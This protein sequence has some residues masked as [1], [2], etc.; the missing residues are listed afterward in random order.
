MSEKKR[1]GPHA[2]AQA[3][4]G[5]SGAAVAA[6]AAAAARRPGASRRPHT[7][8]GRGATAFLFNSVV[9]LS[10]RGVVVGEVRCSKRGNTGT[11][12]ISSQSPHGAPTS[13][14]DLKGR[15]HPQQR[16]GPDARVGD[17]WR[18]CTAGDSN[19][20]TSGTISKERFP[21]WLVRCRSRHADMPAARTHFPGGSTALVGALS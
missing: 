12:G 3:G 19:D 2:T 18:T 5:L 20:G 16:G 21:F 6:C 14:L 7:A 10:F 9:A 1:V 13:T 4:S 17:A 15:Q 11:S 8:A